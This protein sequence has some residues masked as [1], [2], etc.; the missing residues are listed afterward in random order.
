MANPCRAGP[1]RSDSLEQSRAQPPAGQP[2]APRHPLSSAQHCGQILWG[3]VACLG[4][5]PHLVPRASEAANPQGEQW[6]NAGGQGDSRSDDF[7]QS[8]ALKRKSA[9][10]LTPPCWPVQCT[11]Q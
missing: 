3:Q 5:M 4:A 6:L 10:L 7:Q 8:R 11:M 2:T 9:G 1:G